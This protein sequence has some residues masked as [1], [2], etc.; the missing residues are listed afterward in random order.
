MP[1]QQPLLVVEA[2]AAGTPPTCPVCPH[3]PPQV[4]LDEESEGNTGLLASG[5]AGL[6]VGY[7]LSRLMGGGGS[8]AP[9]TPEPAV[10]MRLPLTRVRPDRELAPPD[11][12]E[13][14][15]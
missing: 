10:T 11:S 13:A 15:G 4:D 2:H 6:G 1:A 3:P 5:A 14:R 12:E 8:T 7:L 9:A